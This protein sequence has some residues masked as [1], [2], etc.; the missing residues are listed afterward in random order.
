MI[1]EVGAQN[2]TKYFSYRVAV[3]F[4]IRIVLTI[5]NPKKNLIGTTVSGVL[6]YILLIRNV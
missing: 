1:I 6:Y 3:F 4:A 5:I 2:T